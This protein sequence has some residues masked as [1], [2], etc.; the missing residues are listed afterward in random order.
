MQSEAP[1]T[2]L[3]YGGFLS[4]SGVLQQMLSWCPHHTFHHVLR[5][6]PNML[7]SKFGP[8]TARTPILSL[9]LTLHTQ[10][11]PI[12]ITFTPSLPNALPCLEPTFTRRTSGHCLGTCRA[13]KCP[14]TPQLSNTNICVPTGQFYL[15]PAMTGC[16]HCRGQASEAVSRVN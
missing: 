12:P 16:T 3:L 6:W 5:V 11:N 15:L 13:T 4:F 8:S 14:A 9:S 1:M 7:I 10:N 2:S